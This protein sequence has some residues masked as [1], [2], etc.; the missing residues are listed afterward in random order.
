M[1]T[2]P[3]TAGT[4]ENPL[5]SS[6][7]R[8]RAGKRWWGVAAAAVIAGSLAGVGVT[9]L[10]R[11]SDTLHATSNQ[12]IT[13]TGGVFDKGNGQTAP[14][15]SLPSLRAPANT[16]A[17]SQ[18]HGTPLV[19]NFWA[20]WCPPCRKE[21]PALAATGR[22]LTGKVDF[23]G[24]DTNDQHGAAL[25]FAA[26]TGVAYPL[27]FDPHATAAG[28]YAVYGL[29][30]T[31]FVSADGKILGRQVGGMTEERLAQL[32]TQNFGTQTGT[33]NPAG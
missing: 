29:P 18:F 20:S 12:I 31:F 5:A 23:V 32:I 15:W 26:K 21:M 3:L 22:R 33:T 7:L 1:S 27:A 9:R 25:S 19:I 24:V 8:R 13:S 2:E 6:P 30:T 14:A 28:N 10:A 17:L 16:V 11:P 4:D